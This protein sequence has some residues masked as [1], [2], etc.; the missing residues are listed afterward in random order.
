MKILKKNSK[1]TKSGKLI[2]KK[3]SKKTKPGKLIKKKNKIPY[4]AHGGSF[5]NDEDVIAEEIN[6]EPS[7]FS[8]LE[9]NAVIV[10]NEN[11]QE[12]DIPEN[13]PKSDSQ[14]DIPEKLV[15]VIKPN[16][17][18]RMS[19]FD[20]TEKCRH[21][22]DLAPSLIKK[23]GLDI[24][25]ADINKEEL[26]KHC[27]KFIIANGNNKDVILLLKKMNIAYNEFNRQKSLFGARP[28]PKHVK[29]W[30]RWALTPPGPKGINY[31]SNKL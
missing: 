22:T 25:K 6:E 12:D 16:A 27:L 20:L 30:A 17:P 19:S 31:L 15:N 7:F 14:D 24:M 29:Y 11:A 2:K 13:L 10:N 1:K 4:F 3:N 28:K 8:Q 21:I 9:R 5:G 18:H 26:N 23:T